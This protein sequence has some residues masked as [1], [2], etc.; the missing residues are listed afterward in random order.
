[1]FSENVHT[2]KLKVTVDGSF[3]LLSNSKRLSNCIRAI[4]FIIVPDQSICRLQRQ[5][6][7]QPLTTLR[8]VVALGVFGMWQRLN[9]EKSD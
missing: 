2:R 6:R 3:R 7:G 4:T 1:M 5:T 8:A 9:Q